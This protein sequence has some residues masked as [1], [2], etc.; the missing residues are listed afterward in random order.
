MSPIN[1]FVYFATD[2]QK[3]YLGEDNK[4]V[5]MSSSKGYF[6][7]NK[8]I[9]PDNSG[10]TPDP[11]VEFSLV[12]GE[13]EGD[14]LPEI[15]DLIL[16]IDGCFYRVTEIIDEFNVGT[17]RLTLQGTGTGGS[18]SGGGE[19]AANLRVSHYGGQTRYFS[20]ESKTATLGFMAYSSDK[21]NYVS[22][23]ECSY[24][25]NFASIFS[26]KTNLTHPLEKVYNVDISNQLSSLGQTATKIYVRVTDKYGSQR[27]LLYYVSIAS[28]QVATTEND[29]FAVTGNTYDYVCT[30]GGSSGLET[31]TIKYA[32]YNAQDI[33]VY[34]AQKELEA[35]ES[36]RITKTLD[37]S[38]VSHGDY[39][40]KVYIVGTISGVEIMSNTLTHKVLR[41]D[42]A[43]AQPILAALVPEDIQQY[44][45]VKVSYLLA[46]GTTAKE[47][48]MEIVVDEKVETTQVVT[49]GALND[50]TLTFDRQGTYT[51][52][53]RVNDLG[54]TYTQVLT[55]NKYTGVLPVI[56]VD[57]DDLKVYLTAKGRTNNAADKEY[58]PDYKNSTMK[59]KLS[60]FYFRTVNGWMTDE[61]NVNYLKVS[62]GA[63]VLFDEYRPYYNNPKTSG[64]TVELDFRMSGVTDY[65]TPLISCMACDNLGAYKTG[66]IVT[67][68]SYDYYASGKQIVHLNLVEGERIKLSCVIEPTSAQK[69]PMCYTYLDGIISNAINYA[70]DVDF[71]DDAKDSQPDYQGLLRINSAAGQIDVY[72]V[73]FYSTALDA[74][75]VLNNYQA[76]LDTLAMRQASY[77][78][79]LLRDIDG[80]IDLEKIEAED[81]PLQIPYVKIVGGYKADKAFGMAAA[82]SDNVCALP[83]GKK[84][85]RAIDIE[86]VYPRADQNS[87]F[88]K[89]ENFKMTTTFA[90]PGL[91]VLNGFG[92]TPETGAIMYAQGTSS[93]EYPVKN[94]RVK[95]KGGKIKVRPDMAPVN[96]ICFKADYMD[97]SGSHNT[98]GANFIDAVYEN[99]GIQTPGQ[100]EF[101]DDEAIVTCIKGHPC[102]I[103]WSQTGEPGSFEYI[104]KYN[105]NLDKATPEP[106]GFKTSEKNEKFGYLLKENGE[107]DLDTSG[108]KQNSIYCFEFLDNGVK[109]CNF[110]PDADAEAN[111]SLTTPAEKYRDTWYGNRFNSKENETM[112]GWTIGFESRYPEDKV[113]KNDADVL[114][115]VASWI[116]ELYNLRQTDEA[117][118]LQRFKDE[119][120]EYFDKD[121]LITY[122]LI[123]EVLLMIDSRVKN[124]MI[125]TWGK[126]HRTFEL[127]S[128][129]TKS[130]YNYIWYPIFYDM[131]TMLGLDNAGV[132]N[133][134]YY[135]EDTQ[136]DVY[137]GDCILW[138]FVRDALKEDVQ[139]AYSTIEGA[140]DTFTK[141]YIL[142]YFNSNQANMANET[143]YNEDAMYKYV[144]PFRNGYTD[145][146]NDAV[147]APG[148]GERLYAAQGNRSME[149]D[150]FLDN[151]L[152]FLRGKYASTKYQGG[153]RIEFRLT[154]PKK[155]STAGGAEGETLNA[156]E[157]AKTNASIA[158]VPPSGNFEFTSF[159]TGYAGIKFG[160]NGQVRSQ[161]FVNEQTKTIS[162]DTSSGNGTEMYLLGISNLSD[163]GDLSDKYL[164]NLIVKTGDENH[165]KRLKLGNHHK[166][167][168][169]PYWK[170]VNNIG[171]TGFTYLEEFNLE[172]CAAFTGS[173]NFTASQQI[174]TILL[175]GSS[176]S[177]IQLPPSG[178]ISELR[179]PT[180]V[181]N[182]AIDSH[183]TLTQDNF[184]I[185]YYDYDA[186]TW[187]NDYT[188]LLH[189]SIKNTPIDSYA[190]AHGAVLEPAISRLA[191]YCFQDVEWNITDPADVVIEDGAITGIKILDALNELKIYE[192]L[193]S[194]S[195]A[196]TGK[197]TVNVGNY[198]VNEYAMYQKYNKIYPNLA[199]TYVT[200]GLQSAAIIKFYSSETVLGEPHFQV[201]TDG[202]QNLEFLVSADGPNG[203]KM[204]TPQKPQ[205]NT[206]VFTFAEQWKVAEVSSGSSFTV[207]QTIGTSQFSQ[208]K[209]N[210]SMS[211][212]AVYT[213]APRQYNVTLYDDDGV[214]VLLAEKLTWDA[215]I[216]TSLDSYYQLTYNYKP[217]SDETNPYLQYYF[218][219]WRSGADYNIEAAVPTWETLNGKKISGDFIAYATYELK[220]ASETPLPEDYFQS[221]GLGEFRLKDK[222]SNALQGV[223][224]IPDY[225]NTSQL[226]I[227]QGEN[228][229]EVI[230]PASVTTLGNNSFNRC[231]K[232][233][234]INLDNITSV[235]LSCFFMCSELEL[236]SLPDCLTYISGS[237]FYGCSKVI[238]TELPASLTTVDNYAF[239]T[240]GVKITNFG[241]FEGSVLTTIGSDAFSSTGAGVTS[242]V[243]GSSVTSIGDK[244][245]ESYGKGGLKSIYFRNG[246]SI[247][248]DNGQTPQTMGFTGLSEK[249]GISWNYDG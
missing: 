40:L 81:Y 233:K 241:D 223:V 201:L 37:L 224:N 193:A 67:G 71:T 216:G 29:L 69:Y 180:T 59:A 178:V 30:V 209:P 235:G 215:D 97:S 14:R 237:A 229:T 189:V 6:Y 56:N 28:L 137:N 199:I 12:D 135:D 202:S 33:N 8:N 203:Q 165:L 187:V 143:F 172:N 185:G 3:I 156:D 138:D 87:Y 95:L 34:T 2:T 164:Y 122:Y 63:S 234:K 105:L 153:D 22:G 228:I 10:N 42:E 61:N 195:D 68:D 11:H 131:D 179:V 191:T 226:G 47:Y 230:L 155:G 222:Y 5:P 96:L 151:R 78:Q 64:L 171:L 225:S 98:G 9:E 163:V 88:A 1:G 82:A 46:Y 93:L 7:G 160:A 141:G 104:G 117:T 174:K 116:N 198:T 75:A 21:E 89:Y 100:K 245:F 70:A 145:H 79:N 169:N 249:D 238:L 166:D 103:F 173:I 211:L 115:P 13:I 217:Y 92:Q 74:A 111:E 134:K 54:V 146:L 80:D 44:T 152:K 130:V 140:N 168:Y 142:P 213:S 121:F 101:G 41:Y 109:V 66:F 23:V 51:L 214:T 99:R 107:F 197:L 162:E 53:L 86:V 113:G 119:Y 126:E 133:K 83:V 248:A 192:G 240:S 129:E 242:I 52:A 194:K 150:Y 77:E 60:D 244:A 243:I 196:L 110:L 50:Y 161:R 118:A 91:T 31:R 15:D 108:N 73:R 183:P 208:I 188:R 39:T 62:Q 184:T 4:L 239:S 125:A 72:S 236:D 157:I 65:N 106:F 123:T 176:T 16:N 20:K 186:G 35:N 220:D 218:T 102:I 207:G 158:A 25:S 18:G 154:Y 27:S 45:D 90:D 231:S 159:K 36:G 181:T 232:L 139:K 147:I 210:V 76:T 32:L 177:S 124:M 246:A 43:V 227:V 26:S 175:N 24:D 19:S 149:R 132:S 136:T 84:D 204:S 205:T 170:N 127:S 167:Y 221:N 206:E 114:Y 112:P 212:T 148:T 247:Y 17:N 58:W 49:A 57:R 128:G 120:Q 55:V 85:Y 144:D 190:I 94:L 38:S 48:N 200:T 219:G 182:F